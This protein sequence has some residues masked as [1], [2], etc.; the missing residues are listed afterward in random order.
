MEVSGQLHALAA[1]PAVE[2]AHDTHCIEGWVGLRADLDAVEWRK[3]AC[4]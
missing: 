4:I 3:I 1:I 2:R